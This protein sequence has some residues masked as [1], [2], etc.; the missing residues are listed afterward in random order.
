MNIMFIIPLLL[1]P[2]LCFGYIGPGLGGGFLVAMF[3]LVVAI[4]IAIVGLIYYP[5]KNII[6]RLKKPKN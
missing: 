5:L 4:I 3:G 1:I 6:K 2:N